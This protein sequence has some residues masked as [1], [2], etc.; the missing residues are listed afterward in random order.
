MFQLN[1]LPPYHDKDYL[2]QNTA[3]KL[4]TLM[5]QKSVMLMEKKIHTFNFHS[6]FTE[7]L[8]MTDHVPITLHCTHVMFYLLTSKK[9]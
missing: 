1:L 3:T 7:H 5:Y 9:C 2:F 8:N 4:D 6:T